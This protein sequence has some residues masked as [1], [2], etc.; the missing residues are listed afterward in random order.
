[1]LREEGAKFNWE[2]PHAAGSH[3]E[4]QA[5]ARTLIEDLHPKAFQNQIVNLLL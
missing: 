2:V 1:V 5:L 3:Q 4:G